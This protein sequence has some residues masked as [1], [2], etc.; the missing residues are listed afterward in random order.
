M[1]EHERTDRFELE[2]RSSAASN[3]GYAR[4]LNEDSFIAEYPTYLVADGMGGHDAGDRASA[5]VID[6]FRSLSGRD[7]V[8]VEEVLA[9]AKTGHDVVLRSTGSDNAGTTLTGVIAV[10]ASGMRQWLVLN[11][12]DSRVYR[13]TGHHLEQLTV[14]HSLT[15]ELLD[16]GELTRE[17]ARTFAGRNVI[18]RAFGDGESEIDTRLIPITPR[19]RLLVCSDGLTVELQDTQIARGLTQ[20]EQSGDAA[21]WL[22]DEALEA[23][24]RDN[25]TVI[26]VDTIQQQ[27]VA[28]DPPTNSGNDEAVEHT[29]DARTAP[30]KRRVNRA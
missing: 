25:I 30:S 8:A 7:D 9:L 23:G 27:A 21:T 14:D 10:Q 11:I 4:E 1:T 3:T 6:V 20:H 15:Q 26:I 18:T 13:M 2:I 17:E 19:E 28:V 24:G 29:L 16:R 22:I 5:A 12:G